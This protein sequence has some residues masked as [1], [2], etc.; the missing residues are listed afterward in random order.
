MATEEGA[1]VG[2][3]AAV[4]IRGGVGCLLLD[5]E[6]V[7]VVVVVE[8]VEVVVVWVGGGVCSCHLTLTSSPFDF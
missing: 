1:S 6:V 8:V 7:E 4:G 3:I 2:I 5:A